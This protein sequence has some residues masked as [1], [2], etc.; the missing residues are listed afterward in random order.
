MAL[1]DQEEGKTYFSDFRPKLEDDIN[2]YTRFIQDFVGLSYCVHLSPFPVFFWAS[3]LNGLFWESC[4]QR[5]MAIGLA[6]IVKLNI[7]CQC[8]LY[9]P[10][11][12][13]KAETVRIWVSSHKAI[14]RKVPTSVF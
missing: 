5:Q 1:P 10:W 3:R 8:S 6:P 11:K 9:L 14:Y 7:E 4:S 13:S 2:T 12:P